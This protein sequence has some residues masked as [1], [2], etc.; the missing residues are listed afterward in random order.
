MKNDRM[1]FFDPK[2]FRKMQIFPS[3]AAIVAQ[4]GDFVKKLSCEAFEIK[5]E[6]CPMDKG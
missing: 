2:E 1:H 5:N 6:G 3:V 4:R